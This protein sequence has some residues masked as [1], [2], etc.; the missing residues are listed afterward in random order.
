MQILSRSIYA[1]K[2]C[3]SPKFSRL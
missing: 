3:E 2:V 1:L